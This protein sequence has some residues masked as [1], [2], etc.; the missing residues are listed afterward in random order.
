MRVLGGRHPKRWR[1]LLG[2]SGILLLL[3]CLAASPLLILQH[4]LFELVVL[5]GLSVTVATLCWAQ[6]F[7]SRRPAVLALQQVLAALTMVG[8]V[9]LGGPLAWL[10]VSVDPP[11]IVHTWDLGTK[12]RVDLLERT[13]FLGRCRHL[14]FRTGPTMLEREF[15]IT[16]CLGG[17]FTASLGDVHQDCVVTASVSNSDS[18]NGSL[19]EESIVFTPSCSAIKRP[20]DQRT[21]RGPRGQRGDRW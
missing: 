9:F 2:L 13:N 17:D 18:V 20:C 11:R 3:G 15:D 6:W 14:R 12:A 4:W 21:R 16:N 19:N 5:F 10:A 8:F 7:E 1:A